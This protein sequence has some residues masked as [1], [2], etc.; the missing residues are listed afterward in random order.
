MTANGD[1]RIEEWPVAGLKPYSRQAGFFPPPPEHEVKELAA[2]LEANGLLQPVE[3]LPDKTIVCGHKRVQAAKMLGWTH[4]TVW[5]R[6]DLAARGPA[7]VETRFIQDNVT[8]RQLSPLELGRCYLRLRELAKGAGRDRLAND[9]PQD[10][11]D[12]IGQRLGRS[13][14]TLDRYLSVLR[15]PL[16]SLRENAIAKEPGLGYLEPWRCVS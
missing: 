9:D 10:L 13:G 2:D 3:V 8:R 4:V 11:R 14:R 5:V 15:T 1:R 12:Q 6:E 7:A 16:F